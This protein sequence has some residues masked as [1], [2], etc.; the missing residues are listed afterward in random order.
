MDELVVIRCFRES[1]DLL[2][3]YAAPGRYS[4]LVADQGW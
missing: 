2:L 4:N 3:V 1:I